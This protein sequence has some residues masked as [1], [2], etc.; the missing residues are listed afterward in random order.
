MLL[1][2][3][4]AVRSEQKIQVS[5][6]S[7]SVIDVPSVVLNNVFQTWGLLVRRSTKPIALCLQQRRQE[8]R[9]HTP[10]RF[11]KRNS[12][13]SSEGLNPF[14]SFASYLFELTIRIAVGCYVGLNGA[15]GVMSWYLPGKQRVPIWIPPGRGVLLATKHLCNN[16]FSLLNY[17]HVPKVK[18]GPPEVCPQ[19]SSEFGEG[20][21]LG[22][23]TSSDQFP[24]VFRCVLR[25][26]SANSVA[27]NVANQSTSVIPLKT[28]FESLCLRH[29]NWGG[30]RVAS[31]PFPLQ[32]S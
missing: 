15:S 13:N 11:V 26:K 1:Y 10:L 27:I 5:D 23:M 3:W 32:G 24:L 30:R 4:R 12:W 8:L 18:A 21:S 20:I 9:K 17:C 29:A 22:D 14:R 6:I 19:L 16:I 28:A 2:C 25:L 31:R 7:S